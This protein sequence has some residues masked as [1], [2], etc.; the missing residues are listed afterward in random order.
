M[1]EF[2]FSPYSQEQQDIERQRALAQ[3]LQQQSSQGAPTG[4]MMGNQF[5]PTSPLLHLANA[6][7]GVSG[8][9][10]EQQANERAKALQGKVA[11]ERSSALAEALKL[12]QGTPA[13]TIQPDE[14]GMGMTPM[15]TPA[16]PGNPMAMYGRLA[17]SQDP[18]LQQA[19]MGGM[20]A[21]PER[22][23]NRRFRSQEAAE[24][25]AARL[26]ERVMQIEAAQATA[27]A[28]R[29]TQE[30]LAKMADDTRRE[31]AA[32]Q[33]ET[34]RLVSAGQRATQL[35]IAGMRNEGT[36]KAPAGFRFTA[37]GNL[38]RIPGGPADIK[39]TAALEKKASGAGDVDVALGTLRD[40]YSRLE[41]GGGITSTENSG[42]GNVLPSLASSGVGQS[43]GKMFGT[44]NQS[45]RNDIAMARP[46]LLAALMKATGMSAKQMDSNAELKLWLSTA[47]DPTLDVESNRRALDNIEKKYIGGAT[48]NAPKDDPLGLRKP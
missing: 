28:N 39:E 2:N 18:M 30:R 11:T 1:A 43:V 37:N 26:Q 10:R 22:D 5:V 13:Q 33:D 23:E 38:E 42:I 45:A 21:Q 35:A 31:L 36:N 46:A 9:M 32:A 34:R 12:G 4:Q 7:K 19:G 48:G 47:T 44:N 3:A 16:V 17:Q 27:G 41:K 6:L 14:Q 29:E 8:S 15:E 20:L 40:A 24:Q 25:R